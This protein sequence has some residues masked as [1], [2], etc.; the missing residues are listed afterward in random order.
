MVFSIA[1]AVTAFIVLQDTLNTIWAVRLL[2]QSSFK[3]KIRERIIPFLIVLGAALAIVVYSGL[4][5]LLFNSIFLILK[6]LIGSLASTIIPIVI[7][8]LISFVLGLL[9]FSVIYKEIPNTEIKWFDVTLAGAI[10]GI[11]FTA[12]NS[13][14][15]LYFVAFRSRVTTVEATA[16]A[17]LLLL[18]WIFA[19]NQVI[20]FGAQFSKTY[21]ETYGSRAK[22]S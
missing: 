14:L 2:K 9:L 8:I 7:Q 15:E 10:S 20:F 16:S 13:L 6:P 1:G 18:W 3:A 17:V 19:I 4:A 12:L 22:K 5:T 11:V 21:A